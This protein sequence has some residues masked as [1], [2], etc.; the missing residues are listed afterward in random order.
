[1]ISIENE[2][3]STIAVAVRDKYPSIY[4]TGEYVKSP[5]S[6]PAGS[7][8]E[9]DNTTYTSTQTS[10]EN[11]THANVM[12]EV[13]VYS[14]KAKGKKTECKDHSTIILLK[15][16]QEF[17]LV[18]NLHNNKLQIS[19]DFHKRNKLVFLLFQHHISFS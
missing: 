9:M 14:N 6:F 19:D 11:E 17:P 2:V 15:S 1:M 10:S 3:F 13:N 7:I 5:P 16:I 18:C 4:L 8:V 12:Y